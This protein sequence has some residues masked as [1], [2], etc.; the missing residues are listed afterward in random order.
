M[1]TGIFEWYRN[2]RMVTGIFDWRPDPDGGYILP[3]TVDILP[4]TVDIS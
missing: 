3:L 4:L 2:I 1:V